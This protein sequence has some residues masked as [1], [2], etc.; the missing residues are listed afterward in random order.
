[1]H[2]W[3]SMKPQLQLQQ[4]ETF[5]SQIVQVFRFGSLRLLPD[6]LRGELIVPWYT[7]RYAARNF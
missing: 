5:R 7:T 3:Q 6:G 2:S 1:M 4:N